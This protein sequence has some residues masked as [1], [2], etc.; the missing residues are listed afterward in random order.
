MSAVFVLQSSVATRVRQIRQVQSLTIVII[1]EFLVLPENICGY[2]LAQTQSYLLVWS[3]QR[4]PD[5]PTIAG[6]RLRVR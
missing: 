4:L 5:C 6:I 2:A 1:E 3:D